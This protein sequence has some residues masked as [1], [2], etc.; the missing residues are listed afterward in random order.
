[1]NYV[2]GGVGRNIKLS[3]YN[4]K[5]IEILVQIK[6]EYIDKLPP[7]SARLLRVAQFGY[8]ASGC[9]ILLCCILAFIIK[10]ISN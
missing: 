9:S 10:R 3:D 4:S 8:V 7:K 5:A 2:I 6:D 1:M